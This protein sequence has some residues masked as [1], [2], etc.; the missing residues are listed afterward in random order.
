MKLGLMNISCLTTEFLI[1]RVILIDFFFFLKVCY[2]VILIDVDLTMFVSS[3]TALEPFFSAAASQFVLGHQIPLP[4]WLSLAPV[5]FG[6]CSALFLS[7]FS[8]SL[9]KSNVPVHVLMFKLHHKVL[10]S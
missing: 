5:V 8:S 2:T 6:N 4:L 10:L 7:L 1:V 3:S 9:I